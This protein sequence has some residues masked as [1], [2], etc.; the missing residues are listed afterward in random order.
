MDTRTVAT[1]LTP[2]QISALKE[3]A[4]L[5]DRNISQVLQR[6]VRRYLATRQREAR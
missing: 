5:E 4:R 3:A 2:D 6:L 1:R